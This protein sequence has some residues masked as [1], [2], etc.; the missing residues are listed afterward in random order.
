MPRMS[1]REEQAI[2]ERLEKL[3]RHT[4]YA[5]KRRNRKSLW[6]IPGH[7]PLSPDE[8]ERGKPVLMYSKEYRQWLFDF[9]RQTYGEEPPKSAFN[10]YIHKQRLLSL[11]PVVAVKGESEA[12]PFS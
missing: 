5:Q 11:F 12:G 3:C 2:M 1:D 9:Y 10:R 6:Y 8:P 4:T 7:E